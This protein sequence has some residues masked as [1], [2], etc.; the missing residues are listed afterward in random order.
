MVAASLA[1]AAP[2]SVLYVGYDE[3]LLEITKEGFRIFSFSFLFAG[4]AMYS[5]SFFTALNNG[6]VSAI[7]SFLRML[8]FPAL[9][10]F[11][12]PLIWGVDGIWASLVVSEGFA[13]IV[14]S[15]FLAANRKKYRY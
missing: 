6:L 2:M 1:L 7:I 10:V 9:F 4:T 8:V 5:S 3:T 14:D 11:T 13:V 15:A 12:M